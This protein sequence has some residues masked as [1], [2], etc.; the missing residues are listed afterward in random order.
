MLKTGIK[1]SSETRDNRILDESSFRNLVKRL[2]CIIKEKHD[3]HQPNRQDIE[4][5]KKTLIEP[6][7]EGLGWDKGTDIIC[8]FAPPGSKGR[9]DLI[10]HCRTPVGIE[11][12]PL[13]ESPPEILN[14]PR[15][16]MD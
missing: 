7:L 15:L 12:R 2:S 4:W 8:Q 14:T 11:I 9:L 10:L 16:K 13:H 5:I 6:I 1:H 3:S